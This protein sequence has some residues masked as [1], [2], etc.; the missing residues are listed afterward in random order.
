MVNE[1]FNSHIAIVSMETKVAQQSFESVLSSYL[2]YI[3]N[4][5]CCI[6]IINLSRRR[7]NFLRC[8]SHTENLQ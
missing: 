3:H 6:F 4:I 7:N 1:K 2:R 5:A 8:G